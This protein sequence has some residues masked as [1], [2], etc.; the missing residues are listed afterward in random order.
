LPVTYIKPAFVYFTSG[1]TGK[2][3]EVAH[4]GMAFIITN[5]IFSKYHM[6]HHPDY[7]LF[8]AAGISPGYE[9]M[10]LP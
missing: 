3:K 2:P 8:C 10:G 1:T 6:D 4:A 7:V 5:Y 9:R